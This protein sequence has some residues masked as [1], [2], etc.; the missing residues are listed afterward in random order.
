[1]QY[2]P[3]QLRMARHF[4]SDLLASEMSRPKDK[5]SKPAKAVLPYMVRRNFGMT[6]VR[7]IYGIDVRDP[8]AEAEYVGIPE[9]VLHDLNE[10]ATPGRFLVDFFP[11][12]QFVTLASAKS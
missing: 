3:I 8:V 4:V 6:A 12:S 7:I 11:C 5:L 2:A 9:R 10:C 1:M